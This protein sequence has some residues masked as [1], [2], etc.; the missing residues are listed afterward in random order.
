MGDSMRYDATVRYK[1]KEL[2]IKVQQKALASTFE[3]PD[4]LKATRMAYGQTIPNVHMIL[5]WGTQ[6]VADYEEGLQ[7]IPQDYLSA[8]A[9]LFHLPQKLKHLGIIESDVK[10][11]KLVARMKQLRIENEVPQIILAAELGVARS[12]YACYESGKNIPDILTLWKLAD[13]YDVSLDYLVGRDFN[14][15]RDE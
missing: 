15:E 14:S 2:T 10:K 12:T 7:D 9:H 1:G 3:L 4:F 11:E 13:M 5:D 8:F 6:D